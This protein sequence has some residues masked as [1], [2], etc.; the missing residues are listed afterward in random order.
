MATSFD[1]IEDR[2]LI[3]VDDYKLG[4]L[5]F[6]DPDSFQT[7]C[8]GLLVKAI[9]YFTTCRQSLEYDLTTRE[10]VSNLTNLE[11]QILADYWVLTWWER[12]KNNAAQ[13]QNKL[14]TS[15]G[16]RSFS[17]AMNLKEKQAACDEIRE[18]VSQLCTDY[19][20]QDISTIY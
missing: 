4:K 20:L 13:F 10:F 14:Q 18:K 2:A 9:P 3:V 1:T 15:S 12:Y 5:L 7:F 19:W 8:D 17:E 11:I 6:Q 16:F